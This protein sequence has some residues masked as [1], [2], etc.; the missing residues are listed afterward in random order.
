M[1]PKLRERNFDKQ[2]GRALQ[3]HSLLINLEY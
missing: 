3:G 1:I 2:A